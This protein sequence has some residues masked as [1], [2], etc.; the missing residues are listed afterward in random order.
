MPYMLYKWIILFWLESDSSQPTDYDVY[1][2]TRVYIVM[3]CGHVIL[4]VLLIA[5]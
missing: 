5:L 2:H 4:Y 1:N 3:F